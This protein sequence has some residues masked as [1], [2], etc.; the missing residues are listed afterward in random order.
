MHISV[1]NASLFFEKMFSTLMDIPANLTRIVDRIMTRLGEFDTIAEMDPARIYVLNANNPTQC[2]LV[3]GGET[4]SPRPSGY[5]IEAMIG[6]RGILEE[7]HTSREK[8]WKA[9]EGG[10]TSS[11]DLG[12]AKLRKDDG[13]QITDQDGA[14]NRVSI[15][16]SRL[17]EPVTT[18]DLPMWLR[19]YEHRC[20]E[21][22]QRGVYLFVVPNSLHKNV[23]RPIPTKR[24]TRVRRSKRGH[25]SSGYNLRVKTPTKRCT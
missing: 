18:L 6:T 8:R 22:K 1:H 17:R 15:H 13:F 24:P 9:A 19:G 16:E 12:D 25:K 21:L 5:D 14:V 20:L 7:A 4:R 23:G 10:I 3:V 2:Q 11:F